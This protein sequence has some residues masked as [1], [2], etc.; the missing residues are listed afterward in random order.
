[1]LGFAVIVW[2]AYYLFMP[3]KTAEGMQSNNQ[4]KYSKMLSAFFLPIG[5]FVVFQG[6]ITITD[7]FTSSLI[8]VLRKITLPIS[9]IS[10]AIV[11][12][13]YKIISSK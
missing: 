3:I 2:S 9:V 7:A 13:F 11:V 8:D 4:L 1:M 10:L 6:I 5:I 12:I